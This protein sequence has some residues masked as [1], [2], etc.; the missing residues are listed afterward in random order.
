[1]DSIPVKLM[2]KADLLPPLGGSN[3]AKRPSKVSFEYFSVSS[4]VSFLKISGSYMIDSKTESTVTLLVQENVQVRTRV[5][6]FLLSQ[7]SRTYTNS[8]PL[9]I[10]TNWHSIAKDQS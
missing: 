1:M 5:L 3:L 7:K 4:R 6:F 10:L 8:A 9:N 2:K